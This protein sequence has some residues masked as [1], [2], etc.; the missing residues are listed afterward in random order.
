MP[1]EL[2]LEELGTLYISPHYSKML[3][4]ISEVTS[5][6]D[7]IIGLCT[8]L[9]IVG[10][11]ILVSGNK[12]RNDNESLLAHMQDFIHAELNAYHRHRILESN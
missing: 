9:T 11:S 12:D 5:N 10:S 3:S 4:A 7:T 2:S 8:A 1:D 6:E